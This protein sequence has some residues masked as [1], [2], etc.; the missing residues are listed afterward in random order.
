MPKEFSIIILLM[1]NNNDRMTIC[2]F[3][4]HFVLVYTECKLKKYVTSPLNISA[5]MLVSPPSASSSHRATAP[6]DGRPRARLLPDVLRVACP[7][8]RGALAPAAARPAAPCPRCHP[9]RQSSSPLPAATAPAVHLASRLQA[10]PP[11]SAP[12][13]TRPAF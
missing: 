9:F 8:A 11:F 6:G 3:N 5:H 1:C 4:M 10:Q 12:L 2:I 13:C 7:G